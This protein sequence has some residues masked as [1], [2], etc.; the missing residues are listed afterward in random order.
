MKYYV[1]VVSLGLFQ[2]TRCFR[3]EKLALLHAS[4]YSK[5]GYSVTLEMY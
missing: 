4:I 5:V 1:T 2:D 3:T